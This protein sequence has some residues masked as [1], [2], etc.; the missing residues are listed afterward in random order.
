[1]T[2]NVRKYI[3]IHSTFT[4]LLLYF[5]KNKSHLTFFF[6][7]CVIF[8]KLSKVKVAVALSTSASLWSGLCFSF[9]F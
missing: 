9:V 4:D 8:N 2:R 1:M 5:S 3:V 7:L 6:A